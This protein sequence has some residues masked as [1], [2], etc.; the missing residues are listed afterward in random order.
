MLKYQWLNRSVC[1]PTAES[2]YYVLLGL[3]KSSA[4][5]IAK[6]LH[7]YKANIYDALSRLEELGLV[8]S[9]IEENKRLF[10]P[11]NPEKLP[12]VIEELKEKEIKKIETLQK[13]LLAIIP[14]L[15][16]QYESTK[17]EDV[18]EIYRGRKAYRAVI[19]EIV[20]EKPKE[21]KGFGNLQIQ[22]LFPV[23]FNRWFRNV[24]IRLFSTKTEVVIKREKEAQKTTSVEIRWLPKEVYMP[25]VWVIFGTNL[26]IVIY[27][28]DVV[29]L[30]IK[31]KQITKTFANQFD[32]LW[33]KH[34]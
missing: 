2:V 33:N 23:E 32:Y 12:I 19:N 8:T 7:N 20:K 27:E 18:F 11:T 21:W 5:K 28:P 29:V 6:R 14:Q 4:D 16:A 17:E 9:I 13:E 3:G 15:K 31:S 10:V 1:S 24:T 34:K 30:R 26:L 25:I 22:E